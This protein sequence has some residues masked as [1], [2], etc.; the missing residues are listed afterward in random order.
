M[1][2]YECF[3]DRSPPHRLLSHSSVCDFCALSRLILFSFVLFVRYSVTLLLCVCCVCVW[4][5]GADGRSSLSRLCSIIRVPGL[6]RPGVWG[7]GG[8]DAHFPSHTH[9]HTMTSTFICPSH[10]KHTHTLSLSLSLTWN[11]KLNFSFETEAITSVRGDLTD[12]QVER[13]QKKGNKKPNKVRAKTR[14][15]SRK[16]KGEMME[17]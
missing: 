4:T 16:E 14:G 3:C 8:V 13:K 7:G 5:Y 1:N 9:T 10:P 17:S 12:A 15:M 2:R 11:E 6:N